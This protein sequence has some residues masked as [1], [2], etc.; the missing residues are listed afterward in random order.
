[1]RFNFRP[2]R[3]FGEKK[4]VALISNKNAG[5]GTP[6]AGLGKVIG[7]ILTTPYWHYD[8]ATLSELDEAVRR[9]A[10]ER[11]DVFAFTGGDGSVHQIISRVVREYLERGIAFPKF[12]YIGTGTMMVV[13]RSLGLDKMSAVDFARKITAKIESQQK[14]EAA[15][16]DTTHVNPLMI[17]NESG[18]LYGAGA[19]VNL[20]REY[21][22]GGEKLGPKRAMKVACV[23]FWDELKALL[24]FRRSKKILTKP[25]HAKV[26]L[27]GFDPPVGPFMTHTGLMVASV[28]Q[29]G[30]G[31]RGMPL[32]RSKPNHFMLRST[33][34]GFWGLLANLTP[35]WF[36]V[37]PLPSTFDA[38]VSEL[39]IEYESPTETMID[40]EMKPLT[41]K[42][43][44]WCGPSLEFITG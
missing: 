11:P 38:V 26:S 22:K 15:P 13:A 16:F 14:G 24:T 9:I 28:E 7:S 2:R 19:P 39:M 17:N 23:A 36:G 10:S 35:L 32:A 20:L 41:T 1:M 37:T 44:I 30:M 8:T 43:V 25:V 31:C 12:L 33:Q 21:Y 42:D 34:L 29:L 27:P 3:W 5:K 40:G 18:F 6:R 4:K